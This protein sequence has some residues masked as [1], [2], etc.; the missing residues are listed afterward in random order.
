MAAIG[1][2]L[3]LVASG[4]GTDDSADSTVTSGAPVTHAAATA[5]RSTGARSDASPDPRLAVVAVVRR[6]QQDF[7]DNHSND[8]CSLLTAAGKQ[9]MTTGGRGRTCAES[10]KRVLAQARDSDMELIKRTRAGIHVDDVTIRGYDA[11]VG[12]GKGDRLRLARQDGRWLV[13]DPSP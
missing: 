6:Y 3:A 7:I 1:L 10:V 4:C 5:S 11:M 13:N 2:V 9:Q 8:A 12:I